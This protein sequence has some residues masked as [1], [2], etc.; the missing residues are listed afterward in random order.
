[1]DL[2]ADL[3][4]RSRLI[5]TMSDYLAQQMK[6]TDT[7]VFVGQV[8]RAVWNDLQYIRV[9]GAVVGGLAGIVLAVLQVLVQ[10]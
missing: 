5:E 2:L 10:R 8:E 1:M 3:V 9:N 4:A 7:A 6:R